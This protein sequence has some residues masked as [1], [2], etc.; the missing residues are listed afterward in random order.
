MSEEQG[1]PL[2]LL[3]HSHGGL[4]LAAAGIAGLLNNIAG[5]IF[6]SPYFQNAVPVPWYKH[7]I[8]RALGLLMPAMRV[9]SG[10]RSS[11]LSSDPQMVE[12]RDRDPLALR[13][14]TPRWFATMQVAQKA[15]LARAAEFQTPMLMLLG[16]ADRVAN[17]AG[18]R[19]FFD[20]AGAVDKSLKVYEGLL[21]EVL[22]EKQREEV[23]EDILH[24]MRR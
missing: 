4:V 15:A 16:S 20:A 14:A 21:H 1:P 3:G 2:F 11:W 19:Q 22:R 24:W 8:G 18:G 5:A 17:P 23:F 7:V 6:T 10:L 9:R 12:N 13:F